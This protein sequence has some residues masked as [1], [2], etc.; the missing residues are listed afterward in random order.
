[1][2]KGDKIKAFLKIGLMRDPDWI[3]GTYKGRNTL[4]HEVEIHGNIHQVDK[5][6]L[7]VPAVYKNGN[8]PDLDK[9]VRENWEELK[10][11]V[12]D[13]VNHFFPEE[14]VEVD[15]GEHIITVGGIE[16]AGE[17]QEVDSIARISELPCWGVS[18]L[19]HI[20]ATRWEPD[21]YG[22]VIIG[23]E[24]SNMG[25]AKVLIDAIW[26]LTKSDPYWESLCW[27]A[28]AEEVLAERNA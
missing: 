20:P 3:E 26:E 4:C 27:N 24:S 11:L 16:I 8:C 13:S 28:Y 21:D 2:K 12:T 5:V 9:F 14:K 6:K 17:L 15:E 23:Q 1:M 18:T 19:K 10:K 25:A 7:W 22:E